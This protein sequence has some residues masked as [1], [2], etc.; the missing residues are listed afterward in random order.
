MLSKDTLLGSRGRK[1]AVR[2]SETWTEVYLRKSHKG[3]R[4]RTFNRIFQN[5]SHVFFSS[6][7]FFIKNFFNWN[8]KSLMWVE[9]PHHHHNAC[10]WPNSQIDPILWQPFPLA[11]TS[12]S[13]RNLK[14]FN[15]NGNIDSRSFRLHVRCKQ[16]TE[17]SPS[18]LQLNSPPRLSNMNNKFTYY[19][20]I[21]FS[22]R[23]EGNFLSLQNFYCHS[24]AFDMKIFLF[25]H[26]LQK[27][28][29]YFFIS[30][31]LA[32]VFQWLLL[33]KIEFSIKLYSVGKEYYKI[34]WKLIKTDG[35][36]RNW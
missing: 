32:F 18:A 33:L 13:V 25:F 12:W 9:N 22:M 1:A 29:F 14:I 28:N 20:F 21:Y 27:Q 16:R 10:V 4:W 26:L 6:F 2:W 36:C 34:F 17:N 3:S 24:C 19:N 7:C 5:F 23:H 31:C 11:P 35:I 8:P 15:S 30:C